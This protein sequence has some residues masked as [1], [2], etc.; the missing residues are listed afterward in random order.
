MLIGLKPRWICCFWFFCFFLN[1]RR[2]EF[3]C[4]KSFTNEPCYFHRRVHCVI[5]IFINSKMENIFTRINVKSRFVC[6][7]V[8]IS[9]RLR[10]YRN[11]RKF[12]KTLGNIRIILLLAFILFVWMYFSLEKLSSSFC[13]VSLWKVQCFL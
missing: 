4:S 2:I 8:G 3:A 7:L 1:V 9:P 12:D 10:L 13:S 11:L 6:P 5:Q